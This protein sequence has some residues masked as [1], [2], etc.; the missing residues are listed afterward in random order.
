MIGDGCE[1]LSIAWP[2]MVSHWWF[3]P[4]RF[5]VSKYVA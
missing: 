1:N 5:S 3:K 2:G 4:Q